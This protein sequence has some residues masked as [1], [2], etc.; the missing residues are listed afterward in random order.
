M[1]NTRNLLLIALITA[2]LVMGTSV[3]PM[4]SYA[5]RDNND[6]HKKGKDYKSSIIAGSESDKKSASQHQDQDNFCYRGDD[7][8]Q[9]NQGQQIV[10][11]DNDVK[12]F[13]DQS[14]NLAVSAAAAGAG[15]GTGTGNGT[16]PTPTPPT[17]EQC[18]TKYLDRDQIADLIKAAHEQFPTITSLATL[19][20]TAFSLEDPP[21]EAEAIAFLKTFVKGLSDDAI[22]NL[23]K[24]LKES[25]IVFSPPA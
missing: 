15:N 3:I 7:C 5:D 8:E 4:Q 1:N 14:D 10:G 19:C 20:E 12:G 25:G 16:T 2:T 22:G 6:D 24:C 18:F 9:A 23:I 17:C 21:T 11:K 13:N